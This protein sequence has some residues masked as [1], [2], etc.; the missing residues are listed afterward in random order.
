[1]TGPELQRR[2]IALGF[3]QNALALQCGVSNSTIAHLE[4]LP[5]VIPKQD[6]RRRETLE[7]IEF[8][9]NEMEAQD[10]VGPGVQR[11]SAQARNVVR[12]A[13]AARLAREAF[14]RKQKRSVMKR[15][16]V[17]AR[18]ECGAVREVRQLFRLPE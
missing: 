16:F 10:I 3:S 2:R 9:L 14:Y 6:P 11:L 7:N 4:K 5:G 13:R 18:A 12:A 8:A 1:M 15:R 17:Y